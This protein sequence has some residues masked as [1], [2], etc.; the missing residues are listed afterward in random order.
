MRCLLFR[1]FYSLEPSK[2]A[3]KKL[4]NVSDLLRFAMFGTG[5]AKEPNYAN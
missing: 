3:A 1:L 4:E 5:N 2:A